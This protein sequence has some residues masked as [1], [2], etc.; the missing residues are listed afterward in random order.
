MT[1]TNLAT[2]FSQIAD[3]SKN[4]DDVAGAILVA[5]KDAKA[6]TIVKFM[7]LVDDAYAANGWNRKIGRLAPDAKVTPAPRAVRVYVSTIRR[8]YKLGVK[9]MKCDGIGQVRAGI[10]AAQPAPAKAAVISIAG[11]HLNSQGK[12]NGSPWHDAIVIYQK[13]PAAKRAAM[14]RAVKSMATR[15]GG[16]VAA[17]LKLAS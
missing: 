14:D 8:A 1:K 12:L 2:I 9:V 15:Y 7:R 4:V 13:L 5:I 16:N 6:T 11:V 17:K 3:Q 10:K